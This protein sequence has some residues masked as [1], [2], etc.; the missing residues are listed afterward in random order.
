[1]WKRIYLIEKKNFTHLGIRFKKFT[2][3][4]I[5]KLALSMKKVTLRKSQVA[6]KTFPVYVVR[7][8]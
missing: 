2:E 5:N 7:N 6:D 3:Y 8:E 4:S 1:M